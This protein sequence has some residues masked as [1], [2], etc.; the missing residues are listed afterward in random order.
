MSKFELV[1]DFK[2][3]GDPNG[4]LSLPTGRDVLGIYFV[5]YGK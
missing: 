4:K 2:P 5:T 1:S 3:G